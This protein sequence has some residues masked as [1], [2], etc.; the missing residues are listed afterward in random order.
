MSD[1]MIIGKLV[2]DRETLAKSL[3]EPI[4]AIMNSVGSKVTSDDIGKAI[5]D[6]TTELIV[7]RLKL[8]TKAGTTVTTTTTTTTTTTSDK[9]FGN[10]SLNLNL[11][12]PMKIE[13]GLRKFG[14]KE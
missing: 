14:P 7:P 2:E 1:R 4:A 11:R 5:L 12:M 9:L 8:K 3:Q 13:G 6:P 10:R